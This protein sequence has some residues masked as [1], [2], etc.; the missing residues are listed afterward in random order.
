VK[1]ETALPIRGFLLHL[2]HYDPR[3]CRRKSRERP[4]DVDL[5]LEVIDSLAE[6]EMNLLVIDCADGV[7]YR[8]HPELARPYSVPMRSLK[9]LAA[10]AER[11]GI[12][13][14]P[15]LNFARSPH[16]RHNQWFRPHT[17]GFD[18]PAY[19]RAA[20]EV[21][22][23]LIGVRRPKRFFHVGMDEDHSR[24]Y[25]QYA[26]A[27][28][29]LH[30]GLKRRGLRTVM[31]KDAHDWPEAQCHTE[32]SRAAVREIPRDVVQVPW[33]YGAARPG[34]VRRLVRKGFEVWG[35]PGRTPERV[36]AWRD[37][38][39]AHGGRGILLTLWAPCRPGNRSDLLGV[40][41]TCGP[42]CRGG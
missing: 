19:W 25:T 28:C 11:R 36:R 10:A 27:I 8:S 6:A 4:I 37:A 22:D 35:A 12:E 21:I 16:H 34:V 32:K 5:A 29:T 14:V 23:E 39:L 31:W 18:D 1:R 17:R 2:S 9:R 42:L 13:V 41:R 26:D 38:L 24:S 40:I 30:A 33:D 3:W 15:K 7:R 20:F